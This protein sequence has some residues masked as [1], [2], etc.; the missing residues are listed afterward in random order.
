MGI[1]KKH[2]QR[3]KRI[4]LVI[5]RVAGIEGEGKEKKQRVSVR[6]P[7]SSPPN[8]PAVVLTLSLPFLQPATQANLVR[9]P[10]KYSIAV[11]LTMYNIGKL[12]C[13][14]SCI[15]K[16]NLLRGLFRSALITEGS[17]L[18]VVLQA[19]FT[20]SYCLINSWNQFSS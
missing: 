8:T 4:H 19:F 18:K 9:T 7:S 11:S 17:V 1:P 6:V 5:A 13:L 14:E 10:P 12:F 3:N 2:S 16:N 15:L 20:R